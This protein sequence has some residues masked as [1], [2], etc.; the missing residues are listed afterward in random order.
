MG[1]RGCSGCC[2]FVNDFVDDVGIT[3]G[4]V[5]S[6]RIGEIVG[7]RFGEGVGDAAGEGTGDT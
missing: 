7:D 6:E 4:I 1:G 3:P 5:G 2:G